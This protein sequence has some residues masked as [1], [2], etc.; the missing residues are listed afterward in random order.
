[1]LYPF[2]FSTL[3][4]AAF[5]LLL[6]TGGRAQTATSTSPAPA[7]NPVTDSAKTPAPDANRPAAQHVRVMSDEVASTLASGM[8]KYNPPPKLPEPKPEDETTDLRDTDKPKNRIIRLPKYTVTEPKPP[9]FSE[10]NLHTK[11]E[12]TDMALK[13]YYGLKIGNFGGLN[14]STA[15]L[16]YEEQE[17]LNNMSDLK[18]DAK[19][20]KRSGDAAGSDFISKETNR[21]YYRPSDFGWNSDGGGK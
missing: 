7:T 5:A 4:T 10:R 13:K 16:M 2:R 6:A 9:V 8:P 11:S 3:V 20:A 14:N 12:M 19:T 18:D 17:R 15:L 1:M 21:A